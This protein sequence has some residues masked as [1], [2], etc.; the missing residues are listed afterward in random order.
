MSFT[1]T[2]LKEQIAMLDEVLVLELLDINAT[3]LVDRFE[4]KIEDK[5]E[6]LMYTFE[7]ED[8]ELS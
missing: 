6:Q 3:E 2:E 7:G 1:F 8:N 5:L 4:D